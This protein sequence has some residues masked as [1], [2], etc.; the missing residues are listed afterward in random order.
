M[1][2]Y[3]FVFIILFFF[4]IVPSNIKAQT[5]TSSPYSMYGIG[6]IDNNDYGKP[7]SMG[8]TG[9]AL[10]SKHFLNQI[11]PASLS[12]IDS[13]SFIFDFSGMGRI[14]QY[15]ANDSYLENIGAANIERL[16]IGCRLLPW[17]ATSVGVSPFSSVGYQVNQLYPVEGTNSNYYTNYTGSGGLSQFY[18]ANSVYLFKHLSLGVNADFVFGTINQNEMIMG[19]NF[20]QINSYTTTNFKGFYFNYGIQYSFKL[21]DQ[22]DCVLGAIAGNK[23]YLSYNESL[24][25]QDETARDTVLNQTLGT[26]N[27]TIPFFY[28]I[29]ASFCLNKEFTFTFDFKAQ[30]W[31]TVNINSS[32]I[33]LNNNNSNLGYAEN[34]LTNNVGA[35]LVN[36]N[37]FSV[38]FEYA[39]NKRIPR[40]YL[41]VMKY[42]LGAAYY[43]SYLQ[44]EGV[45]INDYCLTM[46]LGLPLNRTA[47]NVGFEV[48]RRGTT[49][50]NLIVET[51]Y[52]LKVNLAFDDVWFMRSKYQ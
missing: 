40:N 21:N 33:S 5:S 48:G 28:G 45:Q 3:Y 26:G 17:W 10:K 34:S 50:L 16:A 11:N 52:L 47:L 42:R 25:I 35:K 1:N 30:R 29:G 51:Y 2:K 7:G 43:N 38:G 14:T 44:I 37:S 49:N 46:G 13:L 20:D 24:L 32:T 19:S 31:G 15:I 36:S 12:S 22:Y 8:N 4:L 41:E 9:I 39:P 23:Q 18:W 27:F 6:D